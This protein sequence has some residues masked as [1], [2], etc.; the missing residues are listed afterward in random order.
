MLILMKALITAF[1][2]AAFSIMEIPISGTAAQ[3]AVKD[4]VIDLNVPQVTRNAA[5][6]QIQL[7]ALHIYNDGHF[8]QSLRQTASHDLQHDASVLFGF[9]HGIGYE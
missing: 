1:L 5:A 3:T 8:M 7:N 2:L 4:L 9:G 6:K